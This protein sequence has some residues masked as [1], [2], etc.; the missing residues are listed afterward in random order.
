VGF[1]FSAGAKEFWQHLKMK[2]EK[3]WSVVR[4]IISDRLGEEGEGLG[5][6]N[7][8]NTLNTLSTPNTA[9]NRVNCRL[10]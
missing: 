8:L 9:P 1:S 7:T 3:G 6:L 2:N 4:D 5:T 10:P